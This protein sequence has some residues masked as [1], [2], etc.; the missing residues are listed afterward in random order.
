[1]PTLKDSS[2]GHADGEVTSRSNTPQNE[3]SAKRRKLNGSSIAS[4]EN[5]EESNNADGEN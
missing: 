4:S 1:M 3:P 5:S 2:N